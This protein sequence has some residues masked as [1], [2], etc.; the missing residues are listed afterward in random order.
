MRESRLIFLIFRFRFA[1][2]GC[3]SLLGN[4]LGS[5]TLKRLKNPIVFFAEELRHSGMG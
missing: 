4:V 3:A 5:A 1:T 2:Q